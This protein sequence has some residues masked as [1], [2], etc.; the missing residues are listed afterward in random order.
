MVEDSESAIFVDKVKK[1]YR[2]RR[3][4]KTEALKGISL[5]IKRGLIYGLLGPNGAGKSTLI[6]ILAGLTIKTSGTARIYG[7][8]IDKHPRRA[9]ALIGVVPQ[10]TNYDPFF[11]PRQSLELL[12]GLHGVPVRA[13]RTDKILEDVELQ[14]KADAYSR[15]LSG[16]MHRRLMVAKA[17]AHSPPILVLDE[18]TAGVDVHLRRQLWAFVRSLKES[19][20]TILLTTHYIEEAQRLCDD[21]T[22][23]NHG[24]VVA[25]GNPAEL[26]ASV[27]QKILVV[28]LAA[29]LATPFVPTQAGESIHVEEGSGEHEAPALRITYK[30]KQT[31]INEILEQLHAQ[32]VEIRDLSTIEPD[33]ESVFIQLT[34]DSQAEPAPAHA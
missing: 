28:K 15:Q 1:T 34:E 10:E 21:L 12:A 6:N 33:L 7:I 4:K 26:L 27:N 19:G 16:G 9:R 20:A 8:D 11:T 23:I 13:R 2:G 24:E 18:P 17:L 25:R 32:R 3:G 14:D 5:S 22:I 30:P 29:P 31:S